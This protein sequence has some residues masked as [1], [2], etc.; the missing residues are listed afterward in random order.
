MSAVREAVVLPLALLTVAFLGGLEPGA[1]NPW[2]P[3]SIFSLVLAVMLIAA[4]VRSGTL[5]PERLLH[6]SRS[7]LE[8]A[9]GFTVL[10]SLFA[11]TAQLLHMLTPRSGLPALLVGT[12]LFLMLLNTLVM[13]P[14]RP[15][16]LRSIAVVIGSA[17]LLK[18]VILA[19]LTDPEGGRMKRVLLA[20]FDAA[21]LGTISQASL[22]P[23]A[24]YIAFGMVLLFL[25]AITL[26]PPVPY[27]LSNGLQL[28]EGQALTRTKY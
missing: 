9:N 12:V 8:N 4:L 20:L 11:A 13:S 7:I 18:F 16:L 3:P 6:G 28:S 15:R 22:H 24:G 19:A 14:D 5:D 1:L 10:V 21:T 17:F 23:S 2:A 25:G 27:R 26:L